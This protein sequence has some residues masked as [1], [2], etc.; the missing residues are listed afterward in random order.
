MALIQAH[1]PNMLRAALDA[2][3]EN[4]KKDIEVIAVLKKQEEVKSRLLKIERL[5]KLLDSKLQKPLSDKLEKLR[6]KWKENLANMEYQEEVG[7][8]FEEKKQSELTPM[9]DVD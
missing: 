8:P 3:I 2:L 6:K 1:G 5:I 9:E 7:N 4:L